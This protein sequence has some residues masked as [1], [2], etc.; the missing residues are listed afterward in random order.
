M[1]TFKH[2]LFKIVIVVLVGKFTKEYGL[3]L[4]ILKLFLSEKFPRLIEM[5]INNTFKT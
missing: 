4:W 1:F 2:K 5:L 3:I